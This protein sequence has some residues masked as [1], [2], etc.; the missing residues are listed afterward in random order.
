MIFF[1]HLSTPITYQLWNTFSPTYQNHHSAL[2]QHFS[3]VL[4][5]C[6]Q[7]LALS[8]PSNIKEALY[9]YSVIV[10]SVYFQRYLNIISYALLQ[11]T[12]HKPTWYLNKSCFSLSYPQDNTYPSK[13]CHDNE[14][15]AISTKYW[16]IC[17]WVSVSLNIGILY[18]GTSQVAQW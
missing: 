13:I 14:E 18:K 10:S 7:E 1:L 16:G 2:Y 12:E 6:I 8:D 15:W 9:R 3:L 17:H 5:N 11:N 4:P